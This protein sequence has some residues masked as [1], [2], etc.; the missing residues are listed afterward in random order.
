MIWASAAAAPKAERRIKLAALVWNLMDYF[1]Y[2]FVIDMLLLVGSIIHGEVP[3]RQGKTSGHSHC[4]G[5]LSHSEVL[6]RI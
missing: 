2:V 5:L 4:S 3:G 6:R 1:H